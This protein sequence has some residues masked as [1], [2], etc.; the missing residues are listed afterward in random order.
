MQNYKKNFVTRTLAWVL[1]VVMVIAMVPVGVFAA[2]DKPIWDVEKQKDGNY[3]PLTARNKLRRIGVG[4]PYRAVSLGYLGTY[5]NLAGKDVIRLQYRTYSTV[6]SGVWKNLIIKFP[7][8]VF[9]VV[10]WRNP[11]TGMY[12]NSTKGTSPDAYTDGVKTF[13]TNQPK[14]ITGSDNTVVINLSDN[15]NYASGVITTP[16][17]LV[18]QDGALDRLKGKEWLIQGRLADVN[19]KD[20]YVQSTKDTTIIPYGNYT[21]S[22]I[23]PFNDVY[24]LDLT[25]DTQL[26]GGGLAALET[27]PVKSAVSYIRYNEEKGYLDVYYRQVKAANGASK[28]LGHDEAALGFRQAVSKDFYNILKENE[29]GKVA[30]IT[31]ANH[32]DLLYDDTMKDPNRNVFVSRD[33][34]T[35]KGEIGYIQAVGTN[36]KPEADYNNQVKVVKAAAGN[37]TASVIN[38]AD[39]MGNTGVS[40]MVRY[41]IDKDKVNADIKDGTIASYAFY[42]AL[43]R[44]DPWGTYIFKADTGDKELKLKKDQKIKIS[45]NHKPYATDVTVSRGYQ[46][47]WLFIGEKP[48]QMSFRDSIEYDSGNDYIWT[49]PYDMVIAP[50]TPISMEST[51]ESVYKRGTYT[52]SPYQGKTATLTLTN[53]DK[54]THIYNIKLNATMTSYYPR[55]INWSDTLSGG[56]VVGTQN[57]PKVD[58]VFTDSKILTGHSFYDRAEIAVRNI[59]TNKISNEN[60]KYGK[61]PETEVLSRK[62][63]LSATNKS[64][65]IR[66]RESEENNKKKTYKIYDGYAFKTDKPNP[67]ADNK[68]LPQ[69]IIDNYPDFVMPKLLK[70]M[71][72]YVSNKDITANSLESDDVIEQVQAKVHFD[73]NGQKSRIDGREVID[74][75]APLNNKYLF[76][77]KREL[78]KDSSS[79]DKTILKESFEK[80]PDYIPSGFGKLDKNGKLSGVENLRVYSNPELE[81]N[82]E[83]PKMDTVEVKQKLL[84]EYEEDGQKKKKYVDVNRKVINYLDHNNEVYDIK[85]TETT[86]DDPKDVALKGYLENVEEKAVEDLLLRQF[87]VDEEVELPQAKKIIGWTTV[88]LEDKEVD[89]KKVTAEE[90]YYDLVNSKESKHISKLSDWEKVDE[91]KKKYDKLSEEE[92]ANY[93]R[94]IYTFDETSP[95]EDERTVYAVYGGLSIILHSNNTDEKGNG[96]TI[97]RIPLEPRD[98]TRTNNIIDTIDATTSGTLKDKKGKLFIKE[99]PSAPYKESDSDKEEYTKLKEFT[100]KNSTFI[101]WSAERFTNDAN[102]KFVAGTTKYNERVG[103]LIL[104]KVITNQKVYIVP[105]S[106]QSYYSLI[107]DPHHM[108]LPNGFDF[109]FETG[110]FTN[111]ADKKVQTLDELI[112]LGKDIHL[113][114]NYRPFFNVTV[115]PSYNTIVKSNREH[116]YGTYG[117]ASESTVKSKLMIGLIHRTAVTPYDDP[118]V[119]A[120]ANYYPLKP[121]DVLN[122]AELK[123]YNDRIENIQDA[124]EKEE[125]EIKFVKEKLLKEWD[126]SGSETVSWT[127]P[128]YDEYG[129]R[130]SYVSVVVPAEKEAVYKDFTKNK[131]GD[132]GIQTYIRLVKY[133]KDGQKVTVVDKNAPK[134]IFDVDANDGWDIYGGQRAK[135][136]SFDVVRK[137]PTAE[138]PNKTTTDTFTSATARQSETRAIKV[139]NVKTET[140]V[141]GYNIKMANVSEDIPT[142]EFEDISDKHTEVKLKWPENV[143]NAKITDITFNIGDDEATKKVFTLQNDNSYKAEDGTIA[144]VVGDHLVIPTGSLAGKGGKVASAVYHKTVKQG[145]GQPDKDLYSKPGTKLISTTKISESVKNMEQKENDGNGNPTIKFQVPVKVT[146]QVEAGSKYIVQK[147]D[148][149]SGNWVDIA[150]TKTTEDK[151]DGLFKTITVDKESVTHGDIIRIVAKENYDK[152]KYDEEDHGN[153]PFTDQPKSKLEDGYAVPNASTSEEVVWYEGPNDEGTM[154]KKTEK[155]T[156]AHIDDKNDTNEARKAAYK[157]KENKEY[158]IIDLKGPEGNLV[159]E[160]SKY[161]RFVDIKGQL[162]EI[163][164][165]EEVELIIEGEAPKTF[166]TKQGAI[167]YLEKLIRNENM[168]KI[169][170]RAKDAHGNTKDNEVNYTKSYIMT[171]NVSQA[172]RFREF[173]RV[174]TDKA[175]SKVTIK[176]MQGDNVVAIGVKEN[177]GPGRPVKLEFKST[178]DNTT[179]YELKPGDVLSVEAECVE[180]SGQDQI[181]YTSN[182]L[183]IDIK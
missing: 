27:S 11:A 68:D 15:K 26:Y 135:T 7:S 36:W 19:F 91:D 89:G 18:L 116:D 80:N 9:S 72:I 119:H 125:A 33:D 100:K 111:E 157:E 103:Q 81:T 97:V 43:I 6:E 107:D 161:R 48:Y 156:P 17:D 141:T 46:K 77:F 87:P 131:W 88:K 173:V 134:N 109:S 147:Y 30:T 53:V 1:T 177:V 120:D 178:S 51:A 165:N 50:H 60:F 65:E 39:S 14:S 164:D 41:F 29:D 56:A 167:D 106:T 154:I 171:V 176:V 22:T 16:I 20:I 105:Q 73:L 3:W 21:M 174:R 24:D 114:A 99:M 181:R 128:G 112:K 126:P 38:S 130:K 151:A 31:I 163:P 175:N 13:T 34:I 101:G 159:A 133:G 79:T 67:T 90:Q 55:V 110:D 104:G 54:S 148:K 146:D 57:K 140:E 10:E 69:Q 82:A 144:K 78:V 47:K 49:V 76:N 124:T 158:V 145:D 129:Q 149:N 93:K 37:F 44:Q 139:S 61:Y 92:K 83:A 5:K 66:L 166:D 143:A 172:Y 32:N 86:L 84:K 150:E 183:F 52:T 180:G 170:V 102:S 4:E 118:T 113:Y 70:D 162:D 75:V 62:Q 152:A 127:L 182:P 2:V 95:L 35:M 132:L 108:L 23:I 28:G 98:I 137:T 25:K 8:E 168:P 115:T 96:E 74:K 59:D 12:S 136:Q 117:P 64:E 153:D 45:F 58:E 169:V 155:F 94:D 42:S 85:A 63:A 123:D 179:P 122:A 121:K 142:P 160:D 40:T 138:D 71:P